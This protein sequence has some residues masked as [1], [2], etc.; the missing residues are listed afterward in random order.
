MGIFFFWDFAVE[1][2]INSFS[3]N[4]DSVSPHAPM[5]NLN[6]DFIKEKE[7]I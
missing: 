7:E 4:M 1:F 6:Y 3:G 5:I 2:E